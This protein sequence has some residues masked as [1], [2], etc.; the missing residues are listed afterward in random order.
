MKER[1]TCPFGFPFYQWNPVCY[2]GSKSLPPVMCSSV[3]GRSFRALN[4]SQIRGSFL[5]AVS[6][7]LDAPERLPAGSHLGENVTCNGKPIMRKAQT[8]YANEVPR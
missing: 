2:G 7:P 3:T 4:A 6:G 8:I 1:G 5:D